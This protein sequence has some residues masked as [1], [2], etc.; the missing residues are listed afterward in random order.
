MNFDG[1]CNL[2]PKL[3]IFTLDITKVWSL[4][5][6]SCYQ[7]LEFLLIRRETPPGF[8]LRFLK[9]LSPFIISQ[10]SLPK[11]LLIRLETTS[12]LVFLFWFILFNLWTL[13]Y[14]KS[15]PYKLCATKFFLYLSFCLIYDV[16]NC[17]KVSNF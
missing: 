10:L 2:T 17:S 6:T 7:S 12:G 3:N 16:L 14:S 9:K 11:C 8:N 5:N 13:P 15:N 1:C 4:A